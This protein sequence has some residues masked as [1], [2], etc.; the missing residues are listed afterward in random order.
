MQLRESLLDLDHWQV[1]GGQMRYT[2]LIAHM[3]LYLLLTVLAG[4]LATCMG[5]CNAHGATITKDWSINSDREALVVGFDKDQFLLEV[6]LEYEPC[7]DH[8]TFGAT[9]ALNYLKRWEEGEWK[10][11]GGGGVGFL[12][13]VKWSGKDYNIIGHEITYPEIDVDTWV[14][15]Q[16]YVGVSWNSFLATYH[17]RFSEN[18]IEVSIGA[19]FIW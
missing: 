17:V 19:G 10:L 7:E 3:V 12:L 2:V 6:G 18:F 15:L 4:A 8:D 5:N 1:P 14:F 16:T 11:Y 13:E 9:I